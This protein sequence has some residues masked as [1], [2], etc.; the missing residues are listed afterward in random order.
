MATAASATVT[1]VKLTGQAWIRNRDG[2]LTELHEG[3]RIPVNSEIVT[4][5]G[6]ELELQA[7][8]GMP[9]VIGAERELLYTGE[10]EDLSLI[11]I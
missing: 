2:S 1:V 9:V 10:I 4:G 8:N 6:A 3:A 5:P 7:Q 11:H